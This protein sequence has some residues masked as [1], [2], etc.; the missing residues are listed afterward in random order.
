VKK[1]LFRLCYVL[2]LLIIAGCSPFDSKYKGHYKVGKSYVINKKIYHP[3]E[4]TYYKKEGLASWYGPKF[5]G[6]KTANGETFNRRGLTAAHH[7]LPLPSVVKVT[8]LKNQKSVIVVVNDRGPFNKNKE[9]RIID[10]SEKA[11]EILGMKQQ[12]VAKV[13]VELLPHATA[14]L[15]KKLAISNSK[16]VK[17]PQIG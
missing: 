5:H 9:H 7:T 17:T 13:K 3:Q 4:V 14:D 11:A 10:V 15:H 8:N 1:H 6:K 16:F 12:G 2:I